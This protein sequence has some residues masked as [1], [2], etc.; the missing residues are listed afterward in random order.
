MGW[1]LSAEIPDLVPVCDDAC[2]R[3]SGNAG[4]GLVILG[5]DSVGNTVRGNSLRGNVGLPLDLGGDGVSPNDLGE[6]GLPPDG[7]AGPNGLVNFPVGVRR[8]FDG[9]STYISGVVDAG[10]T[11]P[12]QPT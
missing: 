10:G 3:V 6:P 8:D 9:A 1:P 7:D 4:S 5:A 2:N 11:S 12:Q